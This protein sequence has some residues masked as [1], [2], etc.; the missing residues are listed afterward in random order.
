MLFFLGIEHGDAMNAAGETP[1]CQDPAPETPDMSR[2]QV[3][4]DLSPDTQH[5]N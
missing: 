4:I 1:R 5:H 3:E 2:G